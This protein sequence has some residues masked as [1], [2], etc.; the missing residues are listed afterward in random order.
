[1]TMPLTLYDLFGETNLVSMWPSGVRSVTGWTPNGPPD[2]TTWLAALN[3]AVTVSDARTGTA[4]D[5][6]A[7]EAQL[8]MTGS[9]AYPDGFPFV[10][11]SMPDVEFRIRPAIA[12][13]NRIH[14][15]ASLSDR[16][17]EF[18][19]ERVPVEIRL[20]AGLIEPHPKPGGDVPDNT[21]TFEIGD[22]RPGHLDDLKIRYDR[23]LPASI[24]VHLR[25]HMTEDGEFDLRPSV[26]I[27]FGKCLF[28]G[29]PC[30]ALH[31]F[32][33]IPSPTLAPQNVHWLRHAITPWAPVQTGPFDGSFSVR[34][35]HIDPD[36][37]PVAD[38]SHWLNS[39]KDAQVLGPE[40]LNPV[41]AIPTP[42]PTTPDSH[43]EFVL[44]DLVV[45][46]FSP[47]VLPIPRHITIGVRRRVTDPSDPR[48]VFSFDDAPVRVNFS[49]GPISGLIVESFFFKSLP[50]GLGLT[51]DVG[52]LFGQSSD[53]A[54]RSD[55]AALGIGLEEGYT[56]TISYKRNFDPNGVPQAGTGAIATI[57]RLLHFEIATI[58]VDVMT[59][60]IGFSLGRFIGEKASFGDSAL[61]TV[62][63]FVSMPPSGSGVIKLRGL[64][65]EDVKF[66]IEGLG[67]RFG[68][69]HF[70]GLAMPDGV[71]L[72][73][74]DRFGL[75]IQELGMRAEN[76]ATYFSFSGGLLIHIP[77]GFK[78]AFL[79]KRLRFRVSGN[80][81]APPVKVDGFFLSIE[82]SVVFFEVGGYYTET[83]TPDLF[84]REFGLT[85]TVRFTAGG[86][87]YTFGLDFLIGHSETAIETF[88]YLFAQ[89]FFKAS[90]P[91]AM[92][93]LYSIRVLFARNMKPLLD[94]ADKESRELRYYT[95]YKHNDPLLVPGDRRLAGW[96]ARNDSLAFG[97]GASVS[98]SGFGTVVRL[99]AF[100][101]FVTGPD[102]KALLIVID[103]RL[104]TNPKPIAYLALE[105][106]FMRGTFHGVL[107]VELRLADFVSGAPA[108]VNAIG[109][110]TGTI[111]V[112]NDPGTFAIGRLRD[113]QT[114]LRL[115]LEWDF[116]IRTFFE[117]GLCIEV[118]SGGPK[119]FGFFIR[120]EGGIDAKIVQVVYHAG[121]GASFEV[122]AT[123]SHDWAG[124]FWI[125]A[126]LRIVLFG[127]LRFGVSAG[128]NFRIVGAKP[129]R[130]EISAELRLETPWFLPDVTW[131]FEIE[132]GTLAPSD[133]ATSTSP[134]RAA[135]GSEGLSQKGAPLHLERF[136]QNYVDDVPSRTF[137]VNELKA[138]GP[139]ES[140]RLTRFD[141][142]ATIRPV[143]TD[144]TIAV[145]F[146]VAV[147]DKLGLSTDVAPNLG[148]QVSGAL[149]LTYD[150]IRI[151]VRRRARFGSDRSWYALDDRLELP[152][153]FS[154][155][156]GVQLTGSYAAETISARWDLDDVIE[157]KPG[158][159]RLLLN[160]AT[161]FQFATSDPA[162]D[163]ELV[164]DNPQW[165]CCED[166]K[167]PA[168]PV[169]RIAFGSEAPGADLDTPRVFSESA[170]QF[171]F[172]RPA[173]A[174]PHRI[175]AILTANA[176]VADLVVR[177]PGL[178][179]RLEFDED[180]AYCIL[181]MAWT[182]AAG[183]FTLVAFDAAGVTVGTQTIPA[184]PASD[185]RMVL[186]GGTGPIRRVEL[187]AAVFTGTAGGLTVATS[188]LTGFQ[189]APMILE[190]ESAMY[191]SLRDFLDYASEQRS[192][193]SHPSGFH[194]AYEGKGK[195]FFLPNHDYE[196]TLTTRVA[197]AHPS[198]TSDSAEVP[199]YVY[200]RTK[201]LPGLN[202]VPRVGEEIEPYVQSAYA[203][204]RSRLYQREP[205]VLCFKEDFLVAVPVTLRP[206]GTTAEHTT[207]MRMKLL[208]RPDA[209]IAPGTPFT[210]TSE[211]WI[212]AHRAAIV[213]MLP[214]AWGW[215]LS[216]STTM[217]TTMKSVS[218]LRERLAVL[219]QRDDV[220]CPLADPR[221][222]VG[223]V[224][225]AWPQGDP[226]PDDP[227]RQL[228]PARMQ[229]TA[230]VSME[231]AAFVDRTTFDD[232]DLT[233]LQYSVDAGS[234]A[235]DDWSVTNGRLAT[236]ADNE[237]RFAIFGD[238]DWNHLTVS[239]SVALTG[240]SAAG[241]AI[242]IP[243]GLVP[244]Q[245]LFALIESTGGGG[246]RLALYRRTTGTEMMSLAHADLPTPPNATDAV[247]LE[248]TA[249][250]DRIRAT[251]GDQSIEADRSSQREGRVALVAT[252]AATFGNL[253]VGGLALYA[254]PFATS[255]WRS[256]HDHVT[257][258]PGTIDDMAP[259]ALGTG[260]TTSTVAALW[261]ATQADVTAAMLPA[262]DR[263]ARDLVFGR[264]LKDLGIPL[265]DEVPRLEISRFV[266]GG[267]TTCFLLES[268]EPI[269]FSLEVKALLER[270][271]ASSGG[272][273]SVY[274][275]LPDLLSELLGFRIHVPGPI[276]PPVM[277][278]QVPGRG[279]TPMPFDV[280]AEFAR[281]EAALRTGT[282]ESA[283]N[284]SAPEPPTSRGSIVGVS[285][286][287]TGIDVEM[288]LDPADARG[289][290]DD[291]VF[292][293]E[294]MDVSE[295]G[296][297]LRIYAGRIEG[298]AL[299]RPVTRIRAEHTSEILLARDNT[300]ASSSRVSEG[301]RKG[302]VIA[303]VPGLVKGGH[304]G[305]VSGVT[306]SYDPVDV[307][308]VQS[309]S[310]QQALIIPMGGAGPA[311]LVA[312]RYRLTLTMDR[313]RWATTAAPDDVSRYLDAATLTLD[314]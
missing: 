235:A 40:A 123:A 100:V 85:G 124:A 312:G 180:V 181:R 192:C 202:A 8:T 239:V 129:T 277:G 89:A 167:K 301:A 66:V 30:L 79:V 213:V 199:E 176:I 164:K 201:G 20:P 108:W 311:A 88:D 141:N 64:N 220:S 223:T 46:F 194:E 309:G 302:S 293:V 193:A 130:G 1:V 36:T 162:K 215:S 93:E 140:G 234:G 261:S 134:L 115:H 51:F 47:W 142:D 205:A 254:F 160:S 75:V 279:P 67:W 275:L 183:A 226:D 76:S 251:V 190:I 119:G 237:R 91:I 78:G 242:A 310:G 72:L 262:G 185:F 19:L 236:D 280:H 225:I 149:T 94:P 150:L 244:S 137:S 146:A 105:F 283:R 58:A 196:V 184:A 11:E 245:A 112:S 26:P 44:D 101:M 188:Y 31:D 135:G 271:V 269:D 217:G 208:A 219:T 186:V 57:N 221:D 260:T 55:A 288:H 295:A 227:S 69:L 305:V 276:P 258:W 282:T 95:W 265:K 6:V 266:V 246:R 118:V 292:F 303:V 161:P 77:S 204:G 10:L 231:D 159:K 143:A 210:T 294:T 80:A 43:A 145:T 81:G 165:P 195:L 274:P 157:G 212:V 106:D 224:L 168:L 240:G 96:V 172:T 289:L 169:H 247:A 228:W 308:I 126:G 263:A 197:V 285:R 27:S 232:A 144:A 264:W 211:D 73:I 249:F 60:R 48:Q 241:I 222:V 152:P 104:L 290:S 4:G 90:I 273:T 131:T 300:S 34:S 286:R 109:G 306:Y 177:I 122:F 136:D 207:L 16:G 139:V 170:S 128:A 313:P 5:R 178:V 203:G 272:G 189:T 163:E 15:F 120:I 171:R 281:A 74:A 250:D 63:L 24:F 113:Q 291:R 209:S 45:P 278:G 38:F 127:F 298:A 182:T 191:V 243:T 125:E 25:V 206:A 102:E 65:G 98:F 147:N 97:L 37:A 86:V 304:I 21:P 121:L 61:A 174:R 49:A 256:F 138:G 41:T 12:T 252:G 166:R 82:T 114:W 116:F 22:F 52:I 175:G 158:T 257:S 39:H 267:Q 156:T 28:S 132:F 83:R 103:I 84:V 107:G 200:F 2:P 299:E 253:H 151:A 87:E 154:S 99:G 297:R 32:Q 155:S 255:R 111:F 70:E 153:D 233:A 117:A 307:R 9:A 29:I 259:N 42:M 270:R 230:T 71:V 17:V 218:R 198:T 7:V 110:L 173:V 148:D 314:V 268:P 216:T 248:V 35:V 59:I 54:E 13:E 287:P 53:T 238:A 229:H 14:L 68:S 284:A 3:G 187:R 92:V 56:P 296:T 33:L 62:D 133:L 18:V 23:G 214:S 50:S 179:A